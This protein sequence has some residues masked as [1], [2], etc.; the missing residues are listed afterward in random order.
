MN[1]ILRKSLRNYVNISDF[2]KASDILNT[3]MKEQE[4][5][6]IS[7]IRGK[8]VPEKLKFIEKF[9]QV[10]SDKILGEYLNIDLYALFLTEK[11]AL[12]YQFME[13][14]KRLYQSSTT[15]GH[16][17][18]LNRFIKSLRSHFDKHLKVNNQCADL[19]R[20]F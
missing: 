8:S 18:F 1:W 20:K 12:S 15:Y 11:G 6:W 7:K 5:E 10:F 9:P 13:L 4:R 19:L 2:S 14:I 3:K 16:Q 17:M